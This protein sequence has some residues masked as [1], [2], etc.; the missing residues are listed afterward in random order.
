M[1]G[2]GVQS[3]WRPRDATGGASNPMPAC[4]TAA[5]CAGR[6]ARTGGP[7]AGGRDAPAVPG[8]TRCARW[9][10]GGPDGVRGRPAGSYLPDRGGV[11]GHGGPV[12]RVGPHS[13]PCVVAPRPAYAPRVEASL[14]GSVTDPV[15]VTNVGP[16]R[17]SRPRRSPA[18]PSSAAAADNP[19]SGSARTD[20][21]SNGRRPAPDKECACAPTGA[22]CGLG[23]GCHGAGCLALTVRLSFPLARVPVSCLVAGRLS[24]YLPLPRNLGTAD[25]TLPSA[26][27]PR[28]WF[29]PPVR[30]AGA[31]AVIIGVARPCRTGC[32]GTPLS[33]QVF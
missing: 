12:L 22:G 7:C 17:V 23:C 15:G 5:A 27:V 19:R 16:Y 32:A 20:C 3:R 29:R 11:P 30:S 28:R 21:P 25:G 2:S 33:A 4:G 18:P 1:S 9:K 13:R 26:W 14:R 8:L 6:L 10:A 24:L 31:G